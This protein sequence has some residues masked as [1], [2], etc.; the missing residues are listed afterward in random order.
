LT[1]APKS[2]PGMPPTSEVVVVAGALPRPD[3]VSLGSGV[4]ARSPKPTEV[5]SDLLSQLHVRATPWRMGSLLAFGDVLAV[6]LAIAAA[7]LIRDLVSDGSDGY[8]AAFY[9]QQW[10]IG[11]LFAAVFALGGLYPGA[12]YSPPQELRRIAKATT[13]GFL[14]LGTATFLSKNA[15]A[16]SRSVLLMAWPLAMTCVVV[17]RAAIR[18]AFCR[19]Q[20]WGY[21]AA[22]IGT[23]AAA[24]KVI[25]NLRRKPELGLKPAVVICEKRSECTHVDKVPVVGYIAGIRQLAKQYRVPYA[26]VPTQ[27]L[28]PGQSQAVIRRFSRLFHHVLL[29]P[30]TYGMASLWVQP[31]DLGGML[32]LES[33]YRDPNLQAI[34]RASDLIIVCLTMLFWLPVIVAIGLAIKLDSKGPVFFKQSRPGLGGKRF[35]IIKFRTM[36]FGAERSLKA[37]LASDAQANRE[38]KNSGKL[39]S[40]PR[41]T[42]V[43]RWLRKTSLD[44]LPQLLNVLK[45]EMSLVGP[46]PILY[47]QQRDYCRGWGLYMRVRPGITGCW[48]VNG[49]SSLEMGDRIELDRYYVHNW[50]V[51]LDVHLICKTAQAVLRADGAY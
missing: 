30:K 22:V 2:I 17:A 20:W 26:I 35:E 23:G 19:K 42:R 12:P 6:T 15:D 8:D 32:G 16:Y 1:T 49:R 29:V 4:E 34:K 27:D 46:R 10:P 33:R 39:V 13:G 48:Q 21:Q 51:W 7:V 43:G 38:W 28:K 36:Y 37:Y 9:V 14:C 24:H 47:S 31:V 25:E 50:S 5:S 18:S 3:L 44:E 11:F 45:G 40:D 41:V